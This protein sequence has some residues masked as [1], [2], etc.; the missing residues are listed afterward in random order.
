MS[1]GGGSNFGYSTTSTFSLTPSTVG[2]LILVEVISETVADYAIELSSTNV[3]WTVLVAHT[4]L[5]A[6]GSLYISTI[7]IGEVT[8]TSTE[9]V[10]VTYNTGSPTVRIFWAEFNNTTGY[11]NLELDTVGVVSTST[12][13][14]PSLTPHGTG[15]LYFG[16]AFNA[17]S[18]VAG[19][20]SGYTYQIDAN[21]NGA[22]W[23]TDCTG[24]VQTPVW[25]GT[26]AD[27]YGIAV[28][29]REATPGPVTVSLPIARVRN[30][31]AP[32]IPVGLMQI[33]SGHTTG[34]TLTLNFTKPTSIGNAVIICIAGFYDGT[35]SNIEIGGVGS[36][37]THIGGSGGTGSNNAGI[38]ANLSVAQSSTTLTITT[39]A[40][41][42]L[43]W[44]YEVAGAVYFDTIEGGIGTSTSWSSGTT[45]E[46]IPWPHFIV[47]IGSVIAN[48]G[49]ITPTASGWTNE[50]AYTNVVGQD[51]HAIG[52]VSG[53]RTATSSGTYTYSG[54]STNSS[55]WGA[56]V[57]A[58]MVTPQ[59]GDSWGGYIFNEH[60]S[61]TSV[62]ATF[63]LPSTIPVVSG[64]ICSVW[65]GIGDVYQTGVF[66]S[67]SSG[68][69]GNVSTS[70]WSWWFGGGGGAGELWS[71]TAFP[72]GAGDSLT[73][74]LS[75]K[76]QFWYATITN[77]TLDWSYTEAKSVL[78]NNIGTWT[79]NGTTG[80]P[81]TWGWIYPIGV[82]E[83]V[84]E[85]EATLLPN[86][87]TIAFTDIATVPP[88]SQYPV[89]QWTILSTAGGTNQYP[90]PFD[91]ENGS[92]TIHWN[93]AD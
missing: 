73:L 47:G 90:G 44:A 16:Y 69:T 76:D 50:T 4:A 36:T 43:A 85:Q 58:F 41:G 51:S 18:A 42:I 7:F 67:G 22:C 48:T 37:F 23:N 9:T 57:A 15:E 74:T 27:I 34:T 54:T 40:S 84:I 25:G 6:I 77:N 63:T 86:Y 81:T 3:T 82:A 52:A 33:I 71:T 66:L 19:S 12:L 87:G 62:T 17:G 24:S 79:Y 14:F 1:F 55:N 5:P 65:V 26:A 83:V 8:S 38:Y 35:V 21:G 29:I 70:P 88:V 56:A 72:T 45:V 39:S 61:Y 11:G 31:V 32:L 46:T 53:Y 2:D 89:P 20:T 49:S 78:G 80:V 10:T 30:N 59:A 75:Y 60:S 64:A 68:P 28:L 13:N 91:S 93:K 92:Y